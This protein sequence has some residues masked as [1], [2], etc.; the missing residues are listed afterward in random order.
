[1]AG[2]RNLP[3]EAFWALLPQWA[4]VCTRAAQ[5]WGCWSLAGSG[6]D[7][8][9]TASVEVGGGDLGQVRALSVLTLLS[10]LPLR[11]LSRLLPDRCQQAG[12][13]S[14]FVR[15]CGRSWGRARR[16]WLHASEARRRQR[17]PQLQHPGWDAHAWALGRGQGLAGWQAHLCWDPARPAQ[18]GPGALS[19][20]TRARPRP[21][22]KRV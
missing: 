13:W 4:V 10:P 12:T 6:E 3:L 16:P 11:L 5:S 22:W 15:L 1:M 20:C 19:T 7:P 17:S 2:P 21:I 8:T 18:R 14:D 9:P